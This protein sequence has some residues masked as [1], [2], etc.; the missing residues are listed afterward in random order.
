MYTLSPYIIPFNPEKN[1]VENLLQDRGLL[2]D[3]REEKYEDERLFSLKIWVME[4]P[5]FEII[6]RDMEF[7]ILKVFIHYI[8]KNPKTDFIKARGITKI[9]WEF[10][11]LSRIVT[12]WIPLSHENEFKF[13]LSVGSLRDDYVKTILK[14]IDS[15]I[16]ESLIEKKTFDFEEIRQNYSEGWMHSCDNR[17]KTIRRGV[18]YGDFNFQ[19]KSELDDFLDKPDGTISKQEGVF[20]HT[21][22]TKRKVRIL[23]EGKFQIL[24]I[25][26]EIFFEKGRREEVMKECFEIARE[27]LNCTV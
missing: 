6:S 3:E 18:L 8:E 11:R 20:L 24:G 19:E 2:I 15:N 12:L 13:L 14:E 17:P 25:P 7:T 26:K 5:E 16:D 21:N 10:E 23:R 9:F 4:S 22:D 27:L 1:K